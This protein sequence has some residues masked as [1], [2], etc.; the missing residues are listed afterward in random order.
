MRTAVKSERITIL[1]SPDFKA[2]LTREAKK[3]GVSL[4]Q[5]VR[6]R[7]EDKSPNQEAKLLAALVKE[8]GEATARAKSSLDKGLA[9]AEK[10]LYDLRRSA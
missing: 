4:S 10:V 8:L 2:F 9:D 7:C 5:L 1:G 6:Q 3:E